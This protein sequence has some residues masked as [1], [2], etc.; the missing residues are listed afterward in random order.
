MKD[1]Y[2]ETRSRSP[3]PSGPQQALDQV[4]LAQ[5]ISDLIELERF[6]EVEIGLLAERV[7]YSRF[8]VQGAGHGD[9]HAMA[10]IEDVLQ[11]ADDLER[12]FA[13]EVR[14]HDIEGDEIE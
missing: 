13:V 6:D 14:H 7:E 9:L 10:D 12:L 4:R 8:V 3:Q 5:L 1:G 11:S 2:S